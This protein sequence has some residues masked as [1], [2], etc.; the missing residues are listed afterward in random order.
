MKKQRKWGEYDK[1]WKEYCKTRNKVRSMSKAARKDFE[2]EIAR[3][4]KETPKRVFA[5]MNSKV[6]TRQG[7]GDICTDPDDPKSKVTD[8]DK[9][10][11]S[12]FSKF[13]RSVQ[14]ERI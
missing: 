6:K 9:E 3:D 10:K 14:V 5:Y 12:I 11:V 2:M 13:F 8:N 4:S 1:L 7:V